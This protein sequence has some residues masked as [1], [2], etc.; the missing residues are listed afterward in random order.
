MT[1]SMVPEGADYILM[2]EHAELIASGKIRCIKK[3]VSDNICYQ[4]EDVRIGD[5]ILKPG[6]RLLPVHI[7]MLASVGCINPFVYRMPAVAVISTG[8]ELVQPGQKPGKALIRDSNGYQLVAQVSQFGLFGD[9]LGIVKDSKSAL[10]DVLTRALERYELL[11][12]SGGVS[13]GDYDYVPE[14]LDMLHVETFFH[15]MHVRPGKRLLFGKREG[16]YV[17]GMP[18]NP[19]SSLIQF[20]VLVKPLMNRLVGCTDKPLRFLLPLEKDYSRIKKETLSFVPVRLTEAGT[21]ISLEYHGSAHIHAYT[22]ADGIMEIP[23]GV[24][25]LKKGDLV[26]VRPF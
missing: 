2:K 21:V 1:G 19:V 9:Y 7:A 8:N 11:L 17:V 15:G 5:S 26:N 14:V 16:H 12:I 13:V 25:E 24:S 6:T 20:E 18:G 22:G 4:G 3:G 23:L 10:K